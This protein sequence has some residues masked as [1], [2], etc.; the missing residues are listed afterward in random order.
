MGAA[1]SQKIGRI[2][3]IGQIGPKKEQLAAW[4]R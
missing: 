3:P 2:G 4:G 1:L